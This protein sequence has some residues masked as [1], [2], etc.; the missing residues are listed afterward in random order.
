MNL[1]GS[2]NLSTGCD[3]LTVAT[4]RQRHEDQEYSSPRAH[5]KCNDPGTCVLFVL[6]YLCLCSFLKWSRTRPWWRLSEVSITWLRQRKSP[7]AISRLLDCSKFIFHWFTTIWDGWWLWHHASVLRLQPV[8]YLDLLHSFAWQKQAR[9]NQDTQVQHF[10]S[11]WSKWT[12]FLSRIGFELFFPPQTAPVWFPWPL[13]LGLLPRARGWPSH[14]WSRNRYRSTIQAYL[15][16]RNTSS[17]S[18]VFHNIKHAKVSIRK[19]G[20]S[21]EVL[22]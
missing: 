17:D 9:E 22:L 20:G 2:R 8:C 11:S 13:A 18:Y 15:G 5:C 3:E 1:I 16:K 6:V 12:C 7:P 19:F 4:D 10:S 14:L 21:L